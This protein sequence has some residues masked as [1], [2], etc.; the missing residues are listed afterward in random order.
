MAGNRDEF[1]SFERRHIDIDKNELRFVLCD[2]RMKIEKR[3]RRIDF[4]ARVL[5]ERTE[6]LQ[7]TDVVVEKK[8][9][10]IHATAICSSAAEA[11]SKRCACR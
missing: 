8:D 4:E 3:T 9:F 10:P 2:E 1:V 7:Y 5:Q 6:T 11:Q